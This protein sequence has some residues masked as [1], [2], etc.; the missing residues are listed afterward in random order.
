M[1]GRTQEEL[2]AE[3]CS[4]RCLSVLCCACTFGAGP[5]D[6]AVYSVTCHRTGIYIEFLAIYG[7]CA[8]LNVFSPSALTV[9]VSLSDVCK[10][11]FAEV[12]IRG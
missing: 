2:R 5:G 10:V 4:V 9:K 6:C 3:E 1:A 12:E 11:L 7:R 8:R